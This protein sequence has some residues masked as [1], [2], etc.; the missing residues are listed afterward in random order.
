[1]EHLFSLDLRC[2]ATFSFTDLYDTYCI[3]VLRVVFL[4]VK[5]V[6][7]CVVRKA[8]DKVFTYEELLYLDDILPGS[9]REPTDNGAL[10]NTGGG[11]EL[12]VSG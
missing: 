11:L 3:A 7:A 2:F 9:K 12:Q 5:V 8:L 1:L 10:E 4:L 6:A